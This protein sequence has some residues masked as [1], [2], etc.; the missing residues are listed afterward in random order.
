[1]IELEKSYEKKIIIYLGILLILLH[2][3]FSIDGLSKILHSRMKSIPELI[4][5]EYGK[6]TLTLYRKVEKLDTKISD[7]KNH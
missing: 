5:Q 1:M 6:E 3:I 7:F 2:N 4:M